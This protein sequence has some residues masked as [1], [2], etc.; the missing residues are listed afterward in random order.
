V[1]LGF[2]RNRRDPMDRRLRK[3][4]A[5]AEA[6][7]PLR[8]HNLDGKQ[9]RD[10]LD[11]LAGTVE[12]ETT[13][14]PLLVPPPSWVGR[15]LFR[16]AAA[17]FTRKDHGPKRGLPGRGRVALFLAV[18]AAGLGVG[19]GV[20]LLAYGPKRAARAVRA[21]WRIERGHSSGYDLVV[22]DLLLPRLDGLSVLRELQRSRPR[23]CPRR[24]WQWPVGSQ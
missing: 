16:Q 2:L 10:L 22:L 8:L 7:R 19:G 14:N 3:C 1:L 5:F 17:L 12:Q 24:G 9:L 13:A 11:V 23:G 21:F 18:L 15:I 20:G 4:L 6:M